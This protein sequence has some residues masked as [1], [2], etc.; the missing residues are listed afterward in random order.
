MLD[1]FP[2]TPAA[3]S[4]TIALISDQLAE[5]ADIFACAIVPAG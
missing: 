4:L 1:R 5:A 3:L 2:V